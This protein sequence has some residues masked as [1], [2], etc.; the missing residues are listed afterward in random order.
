MNKIHYHAHVLSCV[1][2]VHILPSSFFTFSSNMSSS[3][4][5][6]GLQSGLFP[7]GFPTKTPNLFV[8]CHTHATYPTHLICNL[9]ILTMS[10]SSTNHKAPHYEFLH[11]PVPSSLS[12]RKQ[13]LE[14]C[15]TATDY[16]STNPEMTVPVTNITDITDHL[17]L[18]ALQ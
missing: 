7:S 6:L 1:I 12:L 5:I 11:P 16:K 17:Y 8:F 3:H 14:T 2:P 13:V 10:G 15:L 18:H 4:L 9:F